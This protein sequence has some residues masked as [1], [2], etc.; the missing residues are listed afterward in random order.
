MRTRG[1]IAAVGLSVA[2]A[3]PVGV[4]AAAPRE[5]S[6]PQPIYSAFSLL[7]RGTLT[8][9]RCGAYRVTRGTYAG[10]AASPDPRLAGAVTYTGRFAR[11]PSGTAGVANGRLVIRDARGRVRMR[12]SVTGVFSERSVVNGIV[13]GRL[14]QPAALLLANVT[15]VFDDVLGFGAVRLGLESGANTAVAYPAVPKC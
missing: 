8:H 10:R 13:S 5:V 1:L 9:T 12:G 14:E 4:G 7:K 3:I 6:G 15:M 2:I 11:L